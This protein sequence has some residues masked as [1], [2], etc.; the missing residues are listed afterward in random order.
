MIFKKRIIKFLALISIVTANSIL[1]QDLLVQTNS[2]G[3]SVG[4]NVAVGSHFQRFGLSLNFYYVNNFI[5]TNS[6]ARAYFSFKNLGPNI[7]YNE[8]V[9]SQGLVIGYGGKQN[10]FNPFFNSVSNQT[11]YKNSF[12]YS[13]NFYFNN[14]KTKQV[15]GCVAFQFDAISIITEND[16][17]AKPILDRFRTG[18]FLIQYQFEDKFQTA[19]NC[20]MWTGQMGNKKEIESNKIFSHCYMDTTN[21]VYTNYSHGLLSAQF[22]YNIGLGQNLQANIGIDAEQVRNVLQNKIIHDMKFIPQK[23]NKA[24]NCHIPMLDEKG[25]QY[26]YKT[27][28]IIKPAKLYWNVFSNAN[29]FY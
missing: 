12:A 20:T 14:I 11:A 23:W 21:G 7:I 27:E 1:A 5:Q 6:E 16:I 2:I 24:K 28:Q 3:F 22:K 19:L 18:A 13:Y 29:L 4:A 17:L 10:Y 9:M 25:N 15:T 26:L 8:L